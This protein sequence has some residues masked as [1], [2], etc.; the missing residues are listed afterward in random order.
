MKINGVFNMLFWHFSHD[1]GPTCKKLGF[2]KML[3]EKLLICFLE[4]TLGRP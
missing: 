1:G 3:F 2:K 4:N